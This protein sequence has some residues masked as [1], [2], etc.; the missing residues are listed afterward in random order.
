M[1]APMPSTVENCHS[2][3]KIQ[4]AVPCIRSLLLSP[5]SLQKKKNPLIQT[6]VIFKLP[7]SSSKGN[8]F[9]NVTHLTMGG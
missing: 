7:D 2:S 4:M 8:V 1:P 5:V 3:H 9:S 6:Q